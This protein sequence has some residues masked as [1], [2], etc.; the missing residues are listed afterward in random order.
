MRDAIKKF[1]SA[2]GGLQ[3]V[4]FVLIGL[5]NTIVG[6]GLYAA[7][8][9]FLTLNYLVSSVLANSIAVVI[10]FLLHKFFTFRSKGDIKK[11][12]ARF[13]TVNLLMTLLNLGVLSLC[14]E[15]LDIDAYMAGLVA[16][17]ITGVVSFVCNKWWSFRARRHSAEGEGAL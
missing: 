10:A 7:G 1:Y 15:I 17:V 13:L 12:F 9:Y 4:K 2:M 11:E 14:K 16:L 5:F 8:I 6:Y 3:F